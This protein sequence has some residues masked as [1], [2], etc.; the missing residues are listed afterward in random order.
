MRASLEYI[1][2]EYGA[3]R[4]PALWRGLNL[5]PSAEKMTLNLFG[6]DLKGLEAGWIAFVEARR[7]EK[8]RRNVWWVI[9]L[10]ILVGGF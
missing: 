4:I 2:D 9:N 3:D 7:T 8:L 1:V 10:T 5:T 6:I